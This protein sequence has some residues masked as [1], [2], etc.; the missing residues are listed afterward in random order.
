MRRSRPR[1]TS[2]AQPAHLRPNV[3]G[4]AWTEWVRPIITVPASFRARAISARTSASASVR[5]RA[6]GGAELEREPRVD[7]VAAGEA[8]V[9]VAPLGADGFGDLAH[10]RDHVVVGCQLDLGDAVDVDAGAGGDDLERVG[11]HQATAHLGAADGELHLEH[12]LEARQVRPDGTHRRERVAR[13]HRAVP[14]SRAPA[15]RR[16]CRGGAGAPSKVTASAARSA[17]SRAVARSGPSPT[18]ARTRPPFV[19]NPPRGRRRATVPAWKTSASRRRLVEALDR[20][21]AARV[22][23]VAA[24]PRARSPTVAV[25]AGGEPRGASR[26]GTP[27]G[28][29]RAGAGRGARRG[30]AGSP[31]PRGRRAGRWSRGGPGRGS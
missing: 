4:S 12:P 30:G 21:A 25:V 18:T 1:A 28:P 20:V 31:A 9:E 29:R 27:P 10:E 26:A 23:R 8:E 2:N 17:R 6:P 24:R 7:D 5:R 13:D 14:V 19:P 16:R 11:R 15:R 22:A 3:V